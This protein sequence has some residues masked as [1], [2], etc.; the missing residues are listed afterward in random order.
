MILTKQQWL[1]TKQHYNNIWKVQVSQWFR[2]SRK[3]NQA[4]LGRNF[5]AIVDPTWTDQDKRDMK[6]WEEARKETYEKSS[7]V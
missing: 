1:L 7:R 5:A 4:S 2:V 3:Y 6:A